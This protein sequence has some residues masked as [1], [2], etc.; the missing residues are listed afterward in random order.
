MPPGEALTLGVALDVDQ[1]AGDIVIGR[2]LGADVEEASSVDAE[3]GDDRLGLDLGLAEVAA[4]RLGDVLRLGAARAE[5]DGDI[6]VA[7]RLATG[8][9]LDALR[10]AAR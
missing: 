3:L 4:L 9:D 1:L 7:I 2:D 10:A 5:L 6:A 8:N